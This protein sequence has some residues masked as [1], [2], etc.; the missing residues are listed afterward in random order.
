[1]NISILIVEDG[2]EYLDNLS[3][4]VHGFTYNQAHNGAEAVRLLNQEDVDLIYLDMRF[5][6]I[7]VGDLLGDHAEVTRR[8]NGDPARAWRHLQDN[9]GL[10]ILSYLNEQKCGHIPVVLAYD[11][12]QEQRRFEFLSKQ[13]PL[14][15]WVPDAVT[16]DE[17]RDLIVR[18]CG[19]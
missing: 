1:M 16:P 8:H 14:L 3:R 2:N 18:L 17:I 10:Y 12:T 19:K 11:F 15:A 9:Q 6:R 7:P 5:D 13:H 4:F